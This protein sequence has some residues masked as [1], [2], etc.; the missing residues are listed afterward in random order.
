[1]D[2]AGLPDGGLARQLAGTIDAVV[3]VQNQRI[4]SEEQRITFEDQLAA[5]GI[6]VL[7]IIENFATE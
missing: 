3:L 5:A 2:D 6:A 4:T 1:L 7:G